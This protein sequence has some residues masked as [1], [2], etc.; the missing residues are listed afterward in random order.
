MLDSAI[1]ERIIIN[2]KNIMQDCLD[3]KIQTV[4]DIPYFDDELEQ[5]EYEDLDNPFESEDSIEV[6]RNCKDN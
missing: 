4:L 5:E 6:S 2:Y 1:A 3:N